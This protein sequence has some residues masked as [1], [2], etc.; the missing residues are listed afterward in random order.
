MFLTVL[1]P[2]VYAGIQ[3]RPDTV[4]TSA[5][6]YEP[7]GIYSLKFRSNVYLIS[8]VVKGCVGPENFS[9]CATSIDHEISTSAAR[10]RC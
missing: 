1:L 4:P 5:G 3:F 6:K 10:R 7:L 2:C 9:S 8:V